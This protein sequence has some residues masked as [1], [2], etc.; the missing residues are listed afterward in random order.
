VLKLE[1]G[2]RPLTLLCIG[3]HSDDL[4]IG[5]G[6]TVRRLAGEGRL[7]HVEWVVLSAA[8]ERDAEARAGAA[9]FL[10][11]ARSTT[12]HVERYRDGFF[13]SLLGE[14]KERFEDLKRTVQPDL[15]FTH[16]R[17][18]LHQDHRVTSELVGNTF[19]SHLVLEFE[20][21]KYDG[22][23]ATPNLYVELSEAIAREKADRVM[24]VFASQRHRD[25]FAPEVF[26]ALSRLRGVECRAREGHAEG[27]FARKLVV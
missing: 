6:G 20:I 19:R 27:F 9:A 17:E 13:P 23:L 5:C 10:E 21:P 2:S 3:A 15:V 16:R 26:L 24:A 22:D 18:D 4:E 7:D 8:G 1:L 25:W 12:V 14:L 11:G